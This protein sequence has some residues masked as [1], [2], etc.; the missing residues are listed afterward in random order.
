M[1]HGDSPYQTLNLPRTATIDEVKDAYRLLAKRYHP[2][3]PGGNA[4][5]FK[6][7]KTAFKMIIN[8][9]K[10]GVPIVPQTATSFNELRE[11]AREQT[12]QPQVA[13][14]EFLG[15]NRPI[16]PNR[17]FDRNTFNQ[18]FVSQRN[19][20]EDY[21]ISLPDADYRENRT[22]SSCCQNRLI[23]KTS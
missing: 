16:D 10:Q 2:D 17:E 13:P 23:S 18:K 9:I 11:S 19:D 21:L 15:M 20:H 5:K 1:S 8:N 4:E 6:A 14:H 12:V 22:K 3:R 7:I